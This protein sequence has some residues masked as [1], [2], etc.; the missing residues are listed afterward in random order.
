MKKGFTLIE[1]LV[2]IG[3][4]SLLIAASIGGYSTFIRSA[5]RTKCQELVNETATALT[6]LYQKE[7]NWPRRL[8]TNGSTDGK[9]DAETARALKDYMTLDCDASGKLQGIDRFGI[10]SP[11]AVSVI[12]QSG[13]GTSNLKV[14]GRDIDDHVLHYA[15]DL[16]GDGIIDGAMVG[17][18]RVSV[19]A[20]AIVWCAGK[21]G[22]MEPYSKGVKGDGVY[23]WSDGQAR[24]VK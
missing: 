15:L 19:R 24:S 11:W 18:E 4:L 20:T 9:L 8:A 6:L 2:V 13:N 1:M 16:D 10:V 14:N 17:G 3:I 5:E 12:K 22:R 7:G 21:S 23:S